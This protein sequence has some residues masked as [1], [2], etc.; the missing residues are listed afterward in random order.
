MPRSVSSDEAGDAARW[1]EHS[2]FRSRISSRKRTLRLERLRVQ[3][4]PAP[5]SR[6]DGS[7]PELVAGGLGPGQSGRP[8]RTFSLVQICT[9]LCPA[10]HPAAA[11]LNM[12]SE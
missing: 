11:S 2:G 8:G 12:T 6:F 7:G 5:Q 3:L 9:K 1:I 10:P 4:P